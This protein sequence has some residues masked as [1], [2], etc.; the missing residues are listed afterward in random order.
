VV[1]LGGPA[2]AAEQAR[3]Q[4]LLAALRKRTEEMKAWA[5]VER[6]RQEQRRTLELEPATAPAP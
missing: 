4:D 1:R 6:R 2:D 5:E 3:G